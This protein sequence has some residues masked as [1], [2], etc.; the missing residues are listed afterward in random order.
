MEKA[1]ILLILVLS[2][3]RVSAQ[4]H[5]WEQYFNALLS[6]EDNETEAWEEA[7]C[8]L[9][10]LEE[11]PMNINTATRE[12]LERI[13]FLTD[14][15]VE[16]LCAYLH[17]YGEMRT[18]G[19]L[20]MIESLDPARRL[21]LPYFIYTDEKEGKRRFPSLKTIAKYGKN[22]VLTTAKIPFYERRGDENGYLGYPYRHSMRYDFH[23]GEYVKFGLLGAQDAGEP[24]FAGDN[25]QGFDHYSF[26][27]LLR[28]LGRI[29]ALVVGRYKLNFGMGL[30][31]NNDF[32][33]GKL[34]TLES[35][36]RS[37]NAIRGYSSRSSAHFMQGAAATVELLKGLDLT[38]FA[39]S[40]RVDAT[41][42]R[43]ETSVT[44]LL[45]T[46][47]H[48]T[49][50]E[51][52][53]KENVGKTVRG[54][55]LRFFNRGFHVGATVVS[56]SFSLPLRPKTEQKYRRYYPVGDSFWNA[57]VDYGYISRRISFSGEAATGDTHAVATVNRLSIQPSNALQ[58]LA[59][60]RFYSYKYTAIDAC[61]FSEG[62][63][64]QNESGLYLGANWRPT[65]SFQLMVYSDYARF[66][67]PKYQISDASRAWDN[68]VSASYR[69]QNLTFSARYRIK[70]REKDNADKSRLIGDLTQRAR[71]SLAYESRSWSLKT[72]LDAA[73][74]DYKQ[75]SWG[76][77]ASQNATYRLRNIL[78]LTANVAYFHT[79]DYQS[80]I[81]VY[82]REPL[83]QFYFPAVYG[84]GV[85]YSLFTCADI[86]P[87]LMV[88]G[89]LT[90]TDF[91]DRDHISSGLQRIDHSAIADLELQLRWKF[92][93]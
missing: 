93:L 65:R 26:Y 73:I 6:A 91:F 18:L 54:G 66:A 14:Q 59:L 49:E 9:T 89:K 15:Q 61:S 19:E 88:I 69:L 25:K 10:E 83:Y 53:R 37:S 68:L 70:W 41:L 55:N 33:F 75:R 17:Q 76:W 63:A 60:Q 28:K 29:K 31:M 27:L 38:I 2:F 3:T 12:D 77:M 40:R 44:T 92:M 50:S 67:W 81:Y 80:R 56:T 35:L 5:E 84:Q 87:S 71:I 20:S 64:V 21:L 7:F 24:F 16:E 79:D 85:R 8:V 11:H 43:E 72:Q 39:S 36:G 46:G 34:A 4:Q 42:D 45:K 22:D 78:Q 32:S 62:G 30:V 57:S 52:R 86:S 51:M 82:E 74:N 1:F 23:Y 47:F 48:R 13:P 90:A 58:L